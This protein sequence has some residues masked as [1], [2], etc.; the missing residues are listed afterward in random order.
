MVSFGGS[1]YKKLLLK[2][3]KKIELE[4]KPVRSFERYQIRRQNQII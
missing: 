4:K 1:I 2:Q 3:I